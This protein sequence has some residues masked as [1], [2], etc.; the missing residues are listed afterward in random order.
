MKI[1]NMNKYFFLY[2][3]LIVVILILPVENFSLY[4][5]GQ[6][7]F[8]PKG[9]IVS[10]PIETYIVWNSNSAGKDSID[11]ISF[12]NTFKSIGLPPI[13]IEKYGYFK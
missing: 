4:K 10:C 2:K 11:R 7:Q 3:M 8:N 9:N 13:L 1:D 12:Q 5:D 6:N